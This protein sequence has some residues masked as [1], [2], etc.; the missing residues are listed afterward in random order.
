MAD[1]DVARIV[2]QALADA[3]EKGLDEIDQTEHAIRAVLAAR[4]DMT[5]SAALQAINRWRRG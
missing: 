4:P 1:D 5:V 3:R 2:V